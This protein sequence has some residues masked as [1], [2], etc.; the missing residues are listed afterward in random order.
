MLCN[1]H[2]YYGKTQDNLLIASHWLLFTHRL[3]TTFR[4]FCHHHS[5]FDHRA[6]VYLHRDQKKSSTKSWKYGRANS[7]PNSQGWYWS[8]WQPQKSTFQQKLCNKMCY[9]LAMDGKKRVFAV[10]RPISNSSRYSISE[11][12]EFHPLWMVPNP[13]AKAQITLKWKGTNESVMVWGYSCSIL[14]AASLI[15]PGLA[16]AQSNFYFYYKKLFENH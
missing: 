10:S 9:I 14:K 11:C 15:L 12:I 4:I 1:H 3:A 6:I 2:A 16:L 8:I 7:S 5:K 13:H